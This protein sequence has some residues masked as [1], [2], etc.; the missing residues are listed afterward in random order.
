[1]TTTSS[2]TSSVSAASGSAIL[3]A[4][5]A[6]SGIDTNALVTSLVSASFDP[7]DATLTAKETANTAKVSALGT[8][9]SG[10]DAFATALQSLVTGG[11]LRSQPSS[12]NSAILTATATA[13]ANLSNFSA[14]IEVRQIAQARSLASIALGASST[15]VGLGSLTLT[16]PAGSFNIAV[17]GTNNSLAGL[18]NAI[19]AANTGT[20]P[21]GITA[22]VVTDSSGARLVLKGA[23]GA[24]NTFSIT[25][26]SD[27]DASLARFASTGTGAQMTQ[28]Q[29]AQDAIIR[30]DGVD[31]TYSSNKITA[32]IDGVT[33]NVVSAQVGTSVSLGVSRPTDAITQAVNDYVSAY[34]QLK[35]EIDSATAVASGDGDAGALHGATAIREMQRQLAKISSTALSTLPGGPQTL[36]EIGVSTGQ[37]GTLSVSSTKLASALAS[38]PDAIEAMF[39]PSQRS[40]NPLV[41]ITSALGGTKPGTYT[42]TNIVAG[43]PPSGMIGGVAGLPSA[44]SPTGLVASSTSPAAGLTIEPLGDVVSATVTVD[45][46]LSGVLQSIR[47]SLRAS[48]GVFT[49]LSDTLASEK[50][51]LADA[52]TRME[53][54]E[55]AYKDQLS[56]QF[57][58]MQSRV[59]SYKSIQSYLT[60]QIAAWSNGN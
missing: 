33:L 47:D 31:S 11:T 58:A 23:T 57:S 51:S 21:S 37:D 15:A 53:S 29:A 41:K 40:D 9:S 16:S 56:S 39:N 50:K 2:S 13:G 46:G 7:K 27:A 24:A 17:D 42:L 43:S 3:T 8:L 20:T 1:M 25:A 12:S 54:Q 35:T 34:N 49:S 60:Q 30:M 52:R 55:S 32:L 14:Q 44:S 5:G 4:L 36:A 22:S 18:A 28:A 48:N 6:G 10:I 45:P 19:N 59:A 38:F 26:N